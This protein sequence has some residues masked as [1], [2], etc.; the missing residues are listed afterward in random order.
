[1]E[2]TINYSDYAGN[3]MPDDIIITIMVQMTLQFIS[4]EAT[5]VLLEN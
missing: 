4:W 1:M 5:V 2:I 3:I